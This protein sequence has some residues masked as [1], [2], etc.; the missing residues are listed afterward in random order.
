MRIKSIVAYAFLLL[1][2]CLLIVSINAK[3]KKSPGED[4]FIAVDTPPVMVFEAT[5][6]YPDSAKA[7]NIEGI[8]WIKALVDENGKVI[9]ARAVKCNT[10]GYGFEEAALEAAKK[11]EYTPATQ[12][13]KPVSV[14]VTYKVEFALAEGYKEG[15]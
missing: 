3:D 6:V 11:C 4:D 2:F 1:F 15:K 8:V 5:P 13:E 12:K 9:E 14:W 7:K 10:I